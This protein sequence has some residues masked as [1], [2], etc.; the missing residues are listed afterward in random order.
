M[1]VCITG[2]KGLVNKFIGD[3]VMALFGAPFTSQNDGV[4]AVR[5]GLAMQAKNRVL[6]E[7]RKERGFPPFE[8]GIGINTGEVFTGYIGSPERLDYSVIGDHVNI[9]ARLCSVAGPGQ[10]IIGQQTYE[11]IEDIIDVRS[12]GTP[13]LKGKSESVNAY[14]VL[15]FKAA[16]PSTAPGPS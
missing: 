8:I 6:N 1:S 16:E 4:Q 2:E 11:A 7:G 12:A 13:M 9:A 10:V 3:A 14:E 15:G 5:A